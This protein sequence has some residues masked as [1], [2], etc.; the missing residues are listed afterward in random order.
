M[1]QIRK[2]VTGA[3]REKEK[4]LE[5]QARAR[6]ARNEEATTPLPR[7]PARRYTSQPIPPV[8]PVKNSSFLGAWK[9]TAMVETKATSTCRAPPAIAISPVIAAHPLSAKRAPGL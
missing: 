1:P 4:A 9:M 5:S 2:T 7:A 6:V 3:L 8:R